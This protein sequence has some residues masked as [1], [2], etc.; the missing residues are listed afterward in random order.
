MATRVSE[1]KRVR[2]SELDIVNVSLCNLFALALKLRKWRHLNLLLRAHE[3]KKK[4]EIPT[5]STFGRVGVSKL[6]VNFFLVV[7]AL[8]L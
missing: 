2:G 7:S 5:L 1:G 4:N 3:L 8:L 6:K